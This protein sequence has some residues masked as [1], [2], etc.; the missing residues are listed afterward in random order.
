MEPTLEGKVALVVGGS[1]GLGRGAVE[2]LAAR[3]AKVVALGRDERALAEVAGA[4]RVDTVAGDAA[5]EALAERTLRE[6]R[7]DVL[8]IVA[9]V[10]PAIGAFHQLSWSDF[11]R[12]WKADTKIAFAWLGA[13]LRLPLKPGSHL[14]VIS[15]GAAIGGSPASGGYASAKRAQWFLADYAAM[16]SK[17]AGLGLRVHA[18]MPDINASTELGRA[19]IAEYARRNKISEAEFA[20][21][22]APGLTPAIFGAS[23]AELAATPERWEATGYRLTGRGITPLAPT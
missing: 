7:P 13:A 4:A 23:I 6:R 14:I 8:V 12:N 22:F 15:S 11:E 2:A 1:R 21:R 5:D 10:A 20:N 18:L 9:G 3:G 16:E 19:G 17:R